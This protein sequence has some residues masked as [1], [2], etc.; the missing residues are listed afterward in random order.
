MML[1]QKLKLTTNVDVLLLP[2]FSMMAFASTVE[3]LR[4]AN[5]LAGEALYAWRTFSLDGHTVAAS[6]GIV[7]EPSGGLADAGAGSVLF[8]CAGLGAEHLNEPRLSTRLRELARKG[9]ALGGVCTGTIALA[10]AGLLDDY[11]CTLHWENIEGFVEAFPHLDVTATLFEIDRDRF[12]SSGGTAPMDMTINW[13]GQQHGEDLAVRVAEFLVHHAVRHPHDPQ[14]MPIQYRT[15]ISHPKLLAAIAHMEAYVESPVGLDD[16]AHAVA[17]SPRQLERL[18]KQRLGKTPTR[19]YLE[20][21]L[22]R[23]RLLLQQTSMSVIQV[24]VASGFSSASHFAR[25]YRQ[26]F[27]R[28][29]RTER[30][31]VRRLAR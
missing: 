23:A 15:G 31:D 24:A 1:S 8:V 27:G 3:P 17:L 2:N 30:E 18:F 28:T 12:T 4:A 6:N 9:V 26:C 22:Q 11:R 16:V 20:L 21:R 13:V 10:R 25:C 29:P 19:Y 14:R 5:Q 7:V